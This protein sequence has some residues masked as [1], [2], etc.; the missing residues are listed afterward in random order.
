MGSSE[1]A[2]GNGNDKKKKKKKEPAIVETTPKSAA[3]PTGRPD[4]RAKPKR[5]LAAAKD[6]YAVEGKSAGRRVDQTNTSPKRS[7][8][9][10]SS[11]RDAPTG[12]SRGAPTNLRAEQDA[13]RA[14]GQRNRN[15]VAEERRGRPKEPGGNADRDPVVS[16]PQ[17]AYDSIQ[18][19][20][21]RLE[22]PQ[23]PGLLGGMATISLKDQI[24]KLQEGGTPIMSGTMTVGVISQGGSYTGRPEYGEL[25]RANY[26]K[27]GAEIRVPIGAASRRANGGSQRATTP[28]AAPSQSKPQIALPTTGDS[29]AD[30]QRRAMLSGGAG[31]AARRKYIN[32]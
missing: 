28:A 7:F 19:L 5:N 3:K 16:K 2:G 25:A 26:K 29:T 1:P 24:K 10:E 20:R 6:P 15:V 8:R 18:E 31:S 9:V 30:A 12:A 27:G 4:D 13:I 23:V 11:D 22:N 17:R 14:P 21:G 32:R